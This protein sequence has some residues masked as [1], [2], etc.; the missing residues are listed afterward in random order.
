MH[1]LVRKHGP[2]G[3]FD[4]DVNDAHQP[5]L[6]SRTSLGV[7]AHSIGTQRRLRTRVENLTLTTSTQ[8]Q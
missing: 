4:V 1:L 5:Y 2:H 7:D 6:S 8:D 3:T